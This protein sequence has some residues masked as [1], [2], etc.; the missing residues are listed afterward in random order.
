MRTNSR[1]GETRVYRDSPNSLHAVSV[2][3]CL[4]VVRVQSSV[5]AMCIAG[6]CDSAGVVFPAWSRHCFYT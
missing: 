3:L 6:L 2:Q 1:V 5:D 4:L